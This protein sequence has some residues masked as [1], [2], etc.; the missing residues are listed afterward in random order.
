M[1][2]KFE[3]VDEREQ[4]PTEDDLDQAYG[5]RLLGVVDVKKRFRTTITKVRKEKIKD[6]ESGKEKTRFVVYFK[7]VDKPLALNPTNKNA[8]VDA[9]G[10]KPEEWINADVGV[11]VDPDVTFRGQRTG[12]VRLKVLLPPAKAAP[13]PAA[14]PAKPATPAPAAEEWTEEV[15][16]LDPDKFER[17]A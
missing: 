2:D 9:L 15:D 5:S 1:S 13:A 11:F 14:A 6:R 16:D 8:L 12:G 3:T 7:N 4:T 17:V 10:K